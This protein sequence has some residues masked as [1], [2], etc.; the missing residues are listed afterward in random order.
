MMVEVLVTQGE[1]G[2]EGDKVR[3]PEHT[4]ASVHSLIQWNLNLTKYQGNGEIS[5]F[6]RK[7]QFHKFWANIKQNVH[8]MYNEV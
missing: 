2:M 3:A 7:P 6:Y 1:G 4:Q 5:S 8:N